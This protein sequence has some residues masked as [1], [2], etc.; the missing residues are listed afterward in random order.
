MKRSNNMAILRGKIKIEELTKKNFD[1]KN[2]KIH[3]DIDFCSNDF[4]NNIGVK[5]RYQKYFN[6]SHILIMI[7]NKPFVYI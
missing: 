5:H 4:C 7:Q 1:Y 3:V 2:M 6:T